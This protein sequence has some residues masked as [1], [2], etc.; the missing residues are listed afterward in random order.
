MRG[1]FDRVGVD[2]G[3]VRDR[4]VSRVVKGK[5]ADV[6]AERM[7]YFSACELASGSVRFSV[8]AT[9]SRLDT[10]VTNLRRDVRSE[11]TIDGEKGLVSVDVKNSQPFILSLILEG[12]GG[13]WGGVPYVDRLNGL[14]SDVPPRGNP[15]GAAPDDDVAEYVRHARRGTVYESVAEGAGGAITRDHAKRVF[16]SVLYSGPTGN[17]LFGTDDPVLRSVHPRRVFRS[18]YPTV[19]ERLKEMKGGA[20]G[21]REFAVHM[22]RIEAGLVLDGVAAAVVAEHGSELPFVTVHDSVI[23]RASDVAGVVRIAERVFLD[24]VGVAPPLEVRGLQADG[25]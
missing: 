25:G 11:L 19:Y 17:P 18:V 23:C 24:R 1:H 9:N 2:V 15:G 5:V 10:N 16:L 6:R 20:G 4:A 13:E 21:N 7:A 14:E 22:Q 12:V 3:A 8:N